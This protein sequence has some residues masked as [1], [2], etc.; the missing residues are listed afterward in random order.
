[1]AHTSKTHCAGRLASLPC[2][3]TEIRHVLSAN[4][5]LRITFFAQV[6]CEQSKAE[7]VDCSKQTRAKN[8]MRNVRC[9]M[10]T[11]HV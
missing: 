7:T 4:S 10:L 1:M 9:F 8:V 3:A 6:C 5:T 2:G 11:V